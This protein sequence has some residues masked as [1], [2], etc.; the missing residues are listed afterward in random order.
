LYTNI[1]KLTR[2]TDVAQD[3]LQEV[4]IV[5]WEKR[6]SIDVNQPVANW[7]FSISYYKSVK[8]LKKS[9]KEQVVFQEAEA[10]GFV[11]LESE[12][13]WKENKLDAVRTAI[14]QLSPQ[15]QKVLVGCKL[16]GKSYKE[17]AE[18]LSISKHT[19]KE[20]LALAITS[21]RAILK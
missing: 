17:V 15:K 11:E 16:A 19:V 9:L 5:L 3:I 7:L 18:E 2:D 8:H 14:Q 21:L 6:Q 13:A 10:S 4:F 12:E 1:L 20:Y